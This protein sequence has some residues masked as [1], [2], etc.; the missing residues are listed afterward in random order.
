[1]EIDQEVYAQLR[2]SG[3]F[4]SMSQDVDEVGRGRGGGGGGARVCNSCVTKGQSMCSSGKR[5]AAREE[6]MC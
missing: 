3:K 5:R 1:M 2:D 6:G 4:D